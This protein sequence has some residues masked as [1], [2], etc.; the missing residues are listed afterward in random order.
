MVLVRR[1][2][3]SL[4][5]KSLDRK[6]HP[7]KVGGQFTRSYEDQVPSTFLL[8]RCLQYCPHVY[9]RSRQGQ[10]C[11]HARPGEMEMKV[12]RTS[13]VVSLDKIDLEIARIT[14]FTFIW[15]NLVCFLSQRHRC[16]WASGKTKT[17]NS[18]AFTT[19]SPS[20]TI[21]HLYKSMPVF[22]LFLKPGILCFC[23]P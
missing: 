20:F 18:N 21:S 4:S 23:N 19:L 5:C 8:G 14:L 16:G 10:S 12:W 11:P 1:Q 6:D 9:S 3:N 2:L 7:W 22:F 13:T 17:R 15:Q